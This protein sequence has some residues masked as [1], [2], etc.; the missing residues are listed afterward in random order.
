MIEVKENMS[1][2]CIVDCVARSLGRNLFVE[3]MTRR[4]AAWL[5]S[6]YVMKSVVAKLRSSCFALLVAGV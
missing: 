5:S 6:Q 1:E 4:E 2:A 3:K